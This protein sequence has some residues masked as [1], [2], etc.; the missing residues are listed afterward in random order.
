[1]PGQEND[2]SLKAPHAG[3]IENPTNEFSAPLDS[4]ATDKGW[5]DPTQPVDL[6][7]DNPNVPGSLGE[8]DQ[9]FTPL[10]EEEQAAARRDVIAAR[11][12]KEVAKPSKLR[13]WL[14]AIGVGAVVTTGVGVGAA[15]VLNKSEDTSS[16][17]GAGDTNPTPTPTSAIEQSATTTAITSNEVTPSTVAP[18]NTAEVAPTAV[19]ALSATEI[20]RMS[21]MSVEQFLTNTTYT[22]RVAYGAAI[23]EQ[24]QDKTLHQAN[25]WLGSYGDKPITLPPAASPTNTAEEIFAQGSFT[26]ATI[27]DSVDLKT[28]K[29]DVDEAK[30]LVSSYVMEGSPMYDN[31]LTYLNEQTSIIVNTGVISSESDAVVGPSGNV[32][33][34]YQFELTGDS[35]NSEDQFFQV[36]EEFIPF[37]KANPTVGKWVQTSIK[38]SPTRLAPLN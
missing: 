36:T 9:Q 7:Q 21:D 35:T 2:P 16:P 34:T 8:I 4:I 17:A 25:E 6:D 15:V 26:Y 27:T 19:E 28:F 24:R 11:D 29:F 14:A 30:K 1:M 10:T 38:G 32:T 20:A 12:T 33:K 37:D 22:Q 5:V 23:I 31:V 3:G 18:T 13:K